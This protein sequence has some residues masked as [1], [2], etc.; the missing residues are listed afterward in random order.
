MMNQLPLPV[1]A[2]DLVFLGT[3]RR[4]HGA[5]GDGANGADF[6]VLCN[7][8]NLAKTPVGTA[9]SQLDLDDKE[10]D[11]IR[12]IWVALANPEYT[13]SLPNKLGAEGAATAKTACQTTAQPN[14]CK[15]NWTKWQA[16]KQRTASAATEARQNH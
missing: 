7:L 9:I 3:S 16:A 4:V 1:L 12:E 2:A 5:A 10:L 13:V 6:H 8:V 11:D 14:D 15:K